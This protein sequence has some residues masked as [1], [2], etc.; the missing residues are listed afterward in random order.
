MKKL[1]MIA[2]A[3]IMSAA[4]LNAQNL[5]IVHVNDTHSH[6]EPERSGRSAGLGGAIERAAYID[7]LRSAVGRKNVLYLHGGDFNQGSSYFTQ[8]GGNLEVDIVNAMKY[9]VITLGNHEFDNGVDDLAARL[10]K[11][12]SHVVC[13]NYDFSQTDL[14]KYVKP[15]VIIRKGGMKIGVFGMLT[16]VRRVVDRRIVDKLVKLDDVEVANEVADF[17]KNEK[18]CDMV[19]ALSHLGFRED[20]SL[21]ESVRNLDLVV[22]GHSHT[23][24]DDVEYRTD[25]DGRTVPVVQNGCWGLNMGKIDIFNGQ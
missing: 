17:L 18:K 19:I 22:G 7:S 2:A 5:V 24:L 12:K 23:F 21:V 20:C 10:K 14:V 1:A 3:F 9:D 25:P 13:A 11:V 15:Y 8:F 6:L 4:A 16:D